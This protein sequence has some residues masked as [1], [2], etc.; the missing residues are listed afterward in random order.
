MLPL[1]REEAMATPP[2]G[3]P[4]LPVCASAD[5][6]PGRAPHPPA[7]ALPP[8]CLVHP[9]HAAFLPLQWLL[10]LAHHVP[11]P[12]A[13]AA[14]GERAGWSHHDLLPGTRAV[15][16]GG[17]LLPPQ[18]PAVS[19]Q[20]HPLIFLQH[21]PSP[22]ARLSAPHQTG[23]LGI[24]GTGGLCIGGGLVPLDFPLSFHG[25]HLSLVGVKISILSPPPIPPSLL[26]QGRYPIRG[27]P[28]P[29]FH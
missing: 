15:V 29:P 16:W 14:A 9:L 7:R 28:P 12:Q 10:R 11:R 26:L 1:A 20:I 2:A 27:C 3:G 6:V 13:G 23:G 17:A 4:A 25:H 8:G 19:P 21:P 22:A 5:A 18:G 24:G